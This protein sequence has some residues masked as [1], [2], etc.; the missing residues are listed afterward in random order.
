[1]KKTLSIVICL[2]IGIAAVVYFWQ[3]YRPRQPAPTPVAEKQA[4]P[5]PEPGEESGILH[6]VAE[7]PAVR[8]EP[9]PQVG[10]EEPLPALDKSDE[11]VWKFLSRLFA[12]EPIERF[13]IPENFIQRFV[14]TVDNLPR[15]DL[16]AS[17][18]PTRPVA[19][20]FLVTG[21]ED[22]LVIDP[23]NYRRYAPIIRLVETVDPKRA[24]AI[25]VRFYPLFQQAYVELGYKHGYFNDRLIEVIDHLL[26]TPEVSDP[27]RLAR[28]KVYYHYADPELQALSAGRKIL[29]RTGPKNAARLKGIL[30]QYRRELTA[31]SKGN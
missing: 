12:G 10:R 27:I 5:V 18:L 8:E 24:V 25:Y 30:R 29:I 23:A 2:A 6:P 11:Q 3:T 28:P 19:G 16:P 22:A 17:H 13:F 15:R 7:A 31:A 26:D 4:I 14:V 21:R 20:R 9:K 1:M